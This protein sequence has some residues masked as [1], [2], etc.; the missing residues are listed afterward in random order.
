M[1]RLTVIYKD[2]KALKHRAV[3]PRTHPK[4]QINQLKRSIREFGFVRPVMLD[5]K[6]G[7]I[8]GHGS[9]L[10]A[11][12]LGMNDIPT[13]RV[14]HLSPEQVRAYV[15]A[16]NKLAE[17]AGWDRDLLALELQELSVE[18]H[19]D[20]TVT[21]FETGEVDFLI[22]G[23]TDDSPDEADTPKPTALYPP[24]LKSAIFGGSVSIPYS[25]VMLSR[26][27]ATRDCLQAR[28]RSS[29]LPTRPTMSRLPGTSRGSA[30][31]SIANSRWRP[32]R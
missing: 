32:A 24:F 9:T 6:D 10:A 4:K 27:K 12:E 30:N 22:S 21:G 26:R 15:I 16:D 11:I 18:L 25:V 14:D 28:R 23:L 29:C 20:V 7:I 13:V 2:P 1:P 3:N 8:A 17:N 31:I 5:G 19:F